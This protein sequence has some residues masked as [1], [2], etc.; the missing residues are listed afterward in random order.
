M[1]GAGAQVVLRKGGG[2]G[3]REGLF[4]SSKTHEGTFAKAFANDANVRGSGG[5][6]LTAQA[7]HL[8]QA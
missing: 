5:R 3:V 1:D 8:G 2:A 6:G 7:P 4:V